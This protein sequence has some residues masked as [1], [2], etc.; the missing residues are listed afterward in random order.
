ML[1]YWHHA[2]AI[3]GNEEGVYWTL[4][5]D[6]F[7]PLASPACPGTTAGNMLP[8]C[9]TRRAAPLGTPCCNNAKSSKDPHV[10]L[11]ERY[12]ARKA[13]QIERRIA[14]YFA[15]AVQQP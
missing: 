3:C 4:A 2:C 13:A 7:I 12:G 6:H 15:L 14:A 5:Y 10:W 1:A 8:L 11:V 9:H